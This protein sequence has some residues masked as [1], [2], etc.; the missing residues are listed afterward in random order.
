M[1]HNDT[2]GQQT[3]T[4]Q[5]TSSYYG[6]SAPTPAQHGNVVYAQQPTGQYGANQAPNP[7]TAQQPLLQASSMY[8]VPCSNHPQ[9]MAIDSCTSC[10]KALCVQCKSMTAGK[11]AT[12]VCHDCGGRVNA[13]NRVVLCIFLVFF[14]LVACGIAFSVLFPTLFRR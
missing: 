8:A 14:L 6:S 2:Y 5:A 11:Y 1:Y 9:F 4:L 7:A 13:R 12:V 10:R 3:P